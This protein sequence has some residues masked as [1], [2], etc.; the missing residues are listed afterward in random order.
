MKR[1]RMAIQV[2]GS[3]IEDARTFSKVEH[4]SLAKQIEHWAKLGKCAEENPDLTI[5]MIK[6]ILLGKSQLD[7]GQGIEYKFD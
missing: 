4:R 1:Q 7:D 3:L 5:T 2:S 6:E